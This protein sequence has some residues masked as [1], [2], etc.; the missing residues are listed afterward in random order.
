VSCVYV[1]LVSTRECEELIQTVE[2][3]YIEHGLFSDT[4]TVV[5]NFEK[6]SLQA[7]TAVL[8]E[9]VAKQGFSIIS[10]K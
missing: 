6:V 5:T 10:L 8:G 3:K 4:T 2:N 9:H 1:L 7:V